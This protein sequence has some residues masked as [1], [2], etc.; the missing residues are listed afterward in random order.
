MKAMLI[1]T[2]M[3]LILKEIYKILPNLA[4]KFVYTFLN[5]VDKGVIGTASTADDKVVLPLT[6]MIRDRLSSAAKWDVELIAEIMSLI[7]REMTKAGFDLLKGFAD[8]GLDF[9]ENYVIGTKTDVDDGVILPLCTM[10]RETFGIPDN[11]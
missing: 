9:L 3:G 6:E 4:A 7:M 5:Y 1:R 11:D 2:I 8:E 10:I